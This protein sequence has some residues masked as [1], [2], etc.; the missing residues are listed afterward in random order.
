MVE[1]YDETKKKRHFCLSLSFSTAHY[2]NQSQ[3]KTTPQNTAAPKKAERAIDV[4]EAAFLSSLFPRSTFSAV[5][6]ESI[7]RLSM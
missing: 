6:E 2:I 4:L 7:R 1:Y 5:C 3:T